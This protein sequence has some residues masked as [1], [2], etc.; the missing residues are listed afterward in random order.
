[1]EAVVEF[2]GFKDNHNRFIVKELAVVSKYIKSQ[3][4]FTAPFSKSLLNSKM[5]RTA[6]WLSS[7][8]HYIDW[9][10]GGI[11]YDESLICSLCKPFDTI[12]TRGL[13]KIKFLQQF[14][15]NVK[16]ITINS[17]Y[18]CCKNCCVIP[19]HRN[20]SDVKCALVSATCFYNSLIKTD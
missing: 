15:S 2:H 19:Q 7:S 8:F 13:E 18:E 14:H 20:R 6:N 11:P 3:I 16:D 1:M 10:E 9:N 12:Y 17:K 5:A 4:V